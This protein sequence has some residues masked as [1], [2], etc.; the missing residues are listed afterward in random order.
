LT[1]AYA[2]TGKWLPRPE[3]HK[4]P[5]HDDEIVL[6]IRAWSMG[7][8]TPEQQKLSWR[9]LMY[10]AKASDEFQDLS[11]RPGDK[12][13][14]ATAFAEGSKFVGLMIRKLLR[15]EFTP[16]H[17]TPKGTLGEAVERAKA[18]QRLTRSQRKQ[19]QQQKAG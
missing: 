10:V 9:Y 8:A 13:T 17:V 12:G 18:D 16:K 19:R 3:P 11:Y 4:P 14:L 2:D 15:P 5:Y 6:A 1:T 7:T